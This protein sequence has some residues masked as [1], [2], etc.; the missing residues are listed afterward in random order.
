MNLEGTP[1]FNR[2]F[3]AATGDLNGASLDPIEPGELYK[4]TKRIQRMRMAQQIECEEDYPTDPIWQEDFMLERL[5]DLIEVN[6]VDPVEAD[7]VFTD[8]YTRRNPD[9]RVVYLGEVA[10]PKPFYE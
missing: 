7:Q 6:A 8:W 9:T 1:E 10:V 3:Q 2:G 5:T 4:E